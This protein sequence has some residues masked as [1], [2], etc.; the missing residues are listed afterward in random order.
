[1]LSESNTT[2][3]MPTPATAIL[4][5]RGPRLRQIRPSGS[6]PWP[7]LSLFIL[8]SNQHLSRF[9]SGLIYPPFPT[10]T[11]LFRFRYV[12]SCFLVILF[13]GWVC[14]LCKLCARP[15]LHEGADGQSLEASAMDMEC[16]LYARRASLVCICKSQIVCLMRLPMPSISSHTQCR[17]TCF[18]SG[19][20]T[21]PSNQI[22]K[23]KHLPTS[24]T[25]CRV[26]AT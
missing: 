21:K 25:S 17:A 5:F 7:P 6:P 11:S 18:A 8:A 10:S 1:M 14:V 22:R 24:G 16:N 9:F 13:L 4:G 19:S 2:L 20:T 26:M 23:T 12:P 15:V 3:E